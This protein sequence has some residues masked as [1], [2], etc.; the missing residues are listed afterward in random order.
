MAVKDSKKEVIEKALLEGG[1]IYV[2]GCRVFIDNPSNYDCI[3]APTGFWIR[4]AMG[5]ITY[6]KCPDRPKAQKACN[7]L[8][9][10]KA[11]TVNSKI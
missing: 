8:Y 4:N 10:A 1:L 2:A 7:E 3:E 9:G 5:W 6:F 11:Y